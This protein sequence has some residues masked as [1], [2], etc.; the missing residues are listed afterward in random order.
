M[1]FISFDNIYKFLE[2]KWQI[3]MHLISNE[4]ERSLLPNVKTIHPGV[5]ATFNSKFIWW[6]RAYF[7]LF[8][9]YTSF[10]QL[11]VQLNS[12]GATSLGHDGHILS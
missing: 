7:L 11:S 5:E 8:L 9:R 2:K 6:C 4:I 10:S 1:K 3:C 12:D